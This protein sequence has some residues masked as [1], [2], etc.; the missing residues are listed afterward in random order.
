[1]KKLYKVEVYKEEE[2]ETENE[3][4]NELFFDLAAVDQESP[5]TSLNTLARTPTFNNYITMRVSGMVMGKR[6]IS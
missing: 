5:V 6:C 2:T 3:E 1:M 4:E